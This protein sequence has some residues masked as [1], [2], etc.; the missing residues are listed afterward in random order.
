MNEYN[1]LIRHHRKF[2]LLYMQY[3]HLIIRYGIKDILSWYLVQ[4]IFILFTLL[5]KIESFNRIKIY[6]L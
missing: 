4:I 2:P 3:H 5:S 6:M 1:W